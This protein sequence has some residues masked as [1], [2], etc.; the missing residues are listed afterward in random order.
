[1]ERTN[2]VNHLK[3]HKK[4][5]KV[6]SKNFQQHPLQLRHGEKKNFEKKN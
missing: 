2:S 4:W 1:M 6:V 3:K 5:E